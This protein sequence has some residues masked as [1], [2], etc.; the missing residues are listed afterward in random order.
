[1]A[2]GDSGFGC[3]AFNQF[4][5]TFSI[6]SPINQSFLYHMGVSSGFWGLGSRVEC[7]HSEGLTLE[8]GQATQVNKTHGPQSSPQV[9][10]HPLVFSVHLYE[11]S[12]SPSFRVFCLSHAT[13]T[14]FFPFS[15][16]C[17]LAVGLVQEHACGLFSLVFLYLG[18]QPPVKMAWNL[19][20]LFSSGLHKFYP[21]QERAKFSTHKGVVQVHLVF[22]TDFVPSRSLENWLLQAMASVS[23][24]KT[25]SF[26]LLSTHSHFTLVYHLS[27]TCCCLWQWDSLIT[28]HNFTFPHFWLQTC[29]PPLLQTSCIWPL[30]ISMTGT[31]M[32]IDPD[33]PPTIPRQ[34]DVFQL[35]FHSN[36]Q[37]HHHCIL[38]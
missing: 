11:A 9:I 10:A 36:L 2:F 24:I 31:R 34:G 18:V 19:F 15:L 35:V 6:T 4:L 8:W 26:G 29:V 7:H 28:T 38:G 22:R 33:Y 25:Q 21:L 27:T 32:C 16:Y 12:L 5:D 14:P 23:Y 17:W 1:M 13:C 37:H 3:F 20:L 30:E